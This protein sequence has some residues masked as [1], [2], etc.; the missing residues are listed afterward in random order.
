MAGCRFMLRALIASFASL[1]DASKMFRLSPRMAAMASQSHRHAVALALRLM[2]PAHAASRRGTCACRADRRPGHSNSSRRAFAAAIG[3][4]YASTEAGVGFEVPTEEVFPP[5]VVGS[6]VQVEMKVGTALCI[7]LA[8]HRSAYVG[9]ADAL[10]QEGGWKTGDMI[11]QRGEPR[12]F[13][14]RAG[15]IINARRHEDKPREGKP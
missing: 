13:R 4:A 12:L 2:K 5:C 1:S 3:Q 15:G 10:A 7:S 14:G 6:V 9:G 8:P 11:A